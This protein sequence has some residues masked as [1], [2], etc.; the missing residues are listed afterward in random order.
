MKVISKMLN[1]QIL[2]LLQAVHLQQ[3]LPEQTIYANEAEKS[4]P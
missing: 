4:H 2:H 1:P 3:P